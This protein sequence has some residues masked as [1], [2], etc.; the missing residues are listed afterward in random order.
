MKSL[1]L[2]PLTIFIGICILLITVLLWWFAQGE[3]ITTISKILFAP[4]LLDISRGVGD[5]LAKIFRWV[6]FASYLIV[7]A[8]VVLRYL[9]KG[10]IAKITLSIIGIF[11]A[12]VHFSIVGLGY[13]STG[14]H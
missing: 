2:N 6:T 9:A 12:I 4:F 5:S 14:L 11:L 3:S 7:I 10:K 8:I 13:V 1:L